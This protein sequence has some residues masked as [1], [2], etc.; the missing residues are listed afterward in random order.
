MSQRR[1]SEMDH[2]RRLA[3]GSCPVHGLSMGQVDGWYVGRDGRDYTIVG[4][5]RSDV[6]SGQ[7]PLML[8]GHARASLYRTLP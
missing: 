6:P 5:P 4:C 7:S 2:A 1:Q 3:R 8:T